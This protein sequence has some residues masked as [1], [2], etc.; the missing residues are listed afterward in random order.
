MSRLGVAPA[1]VQAI[2]GMQ[3]DVA[4][5][6]TRLADATGNVQSLGLIA[7]P[8]DSALT[9]TL[10][11]RRST[12]RTAAASSEALDA[13][14]RQAA[15]LYERGDVEGAQELK[16]AADVLEADV[17]AA[18]G[19]GS[20]TEAPEAGGGADGTGQLAGQ[21][22]QQVGSVAS[23]VG[24]AM[25]GLMQGLAAIPGTALQAAQ[26]AG[27]S[28]GALDPPGAAADEQAGDERSDESD[29]RD[30][31]DDEADANDDV[32]RATDPTAGPGEQRGTAP[33]EP[34]APEAPRAERPA[35]AQTRP[36][37]VG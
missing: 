13:I 36:A 10:A 34:D 1:E 28:G 16:R 33:A 21:V 24:Q 37:G 29:G 14:L 9:A 19:P 7:A 27:Q 15:R 25:A 5:E 22:G 20:A 23:T 11:S 17:A 4:A 2:A 12:L 18:G 8:V 35:P 32:Q 31:D 3:G 30:E 6:L 26:G